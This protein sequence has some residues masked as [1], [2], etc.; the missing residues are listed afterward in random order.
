MG[1]FL[2]FCIDIMHCTASDLN[3]IAVMVMMLIVA[4][5]AQESC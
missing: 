4:A 3:T 2:L 1:L 5:E